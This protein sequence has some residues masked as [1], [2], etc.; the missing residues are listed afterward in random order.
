MIVEKLLLNYDYFC[1]ILSIE[2]K[3]AL[4]NVMRTDTEEVGIRYMMLR[5]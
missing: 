4:L 1:N 5:S 3:K 2:K